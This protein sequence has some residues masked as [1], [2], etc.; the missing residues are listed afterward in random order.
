MFWGC[1]NRV[2]AKLV[3]YMSAWRKKTIEIIDVLI[4]R[5]D[6]HNIFEV[7]CDDAGISRKLA[8]K[9]HKIQL[10]GVDFRKDK[11]NLANQL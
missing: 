3:K 6:I 2:K 7:G 4:S 9:Y 1:S 11:I 10:T 5:H 8:E